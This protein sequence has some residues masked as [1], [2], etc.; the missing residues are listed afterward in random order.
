VGGGGGRVAGAVVGLLARGGA[1]AWVGRADREELAFVAQVAAID[2]VAV[3]LAADEAAGPTDDAAEEAR[4]AFREEQVL[5]LALGVA[6]SLHVAREDFARALREFAPKETAWLVQ[7]AGVFE[8]G[9]LGAVLEHIMELD[10]AYL[11]RDKGAAEGSRIQIK[12]SRVRRVARSVAEGLVE[13]GLSKIRRK[14]LFE[15]EADA[16]DWL[17]FRMRTGA[18]LQERME[19]LQLE[20]ELTRIV[21]GLWEKASH[22]VDVHVCINLAA[23]DKVTTNLSARITEI[24]GRYGITLSSGAARPGRDA[25]HE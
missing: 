13:T 23:L 22:K 6:V 19:F 20:P 12:T 8:A 15:D 17:L 9:H 14:Q 10:F 3:E 5:A 16:A 11:L 21:A 25:T 4:R 24:L 2:A 1:A 7:T 18:E